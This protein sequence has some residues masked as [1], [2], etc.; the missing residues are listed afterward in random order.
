MLPAMIHILRPIIMPAMETMIQPNHDARRN[1]DAIMV[2]VVTL[3]YFYMSDLLSVKPPEQ[4]VRTPIA[5]WNDGVKRTPPRTPASQPK[6]MKPRP[7]DTREF[8]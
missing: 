3:G 1:T 6:V 2:I 5:L 7:P 4:I 8:R